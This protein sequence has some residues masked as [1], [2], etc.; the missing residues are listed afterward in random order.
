MAHQSGF[1]TG[2]AFDKLMDAVDLQEQP[3]AYPVGGSSARW[4]RNRRATRHEQKE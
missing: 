2:T 4:L 3:V 1:A